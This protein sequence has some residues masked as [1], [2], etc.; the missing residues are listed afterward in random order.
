MPLFKRTRNTLKKAFSYD[1]IKRQNVFIIEI[2][3]SLFKKKKTNNNH[4]FEQL[5][6]LGVDKKKLTSALNRFTWL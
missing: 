3:K 1:E 6:S 4:T 2:V 5:E